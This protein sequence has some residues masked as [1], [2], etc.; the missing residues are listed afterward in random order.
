[1]DR[2]DIKGAVGVCALS[3]LHLGLTLDDLLAVSL[4]AK[5]I[6]LSLLRLR[7]PDKH[8][9]VSFIHQF[10]PAA[11]V[12]MLVAAT[13]EGGASELVKV[14]VDARPGQEQAERAE[15]LALAYAV[16]V[17]CYR[18]QEV[19]DW[20]PNSFSEAL[21]RG[22]FTEDGF[23]W[24]YL[25]H[26]GRMA[27]KGRKSYEPARIGRNLHLFNGAENMPDLLDSLQA[28]QSF[29]RDYPKALLNH[30]DSEPFKAFL[31][32]LGGMGAVAYLSVEFDD[33]MRVLK[34]F[35]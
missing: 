27:L 20:S 7:E 18:L 21:E 12:G 9:L 15:A 8:S 16:Y 6:A 31:S 29:I 35:K 26:L 13:V 3:D 10:T 17:A 22:D 5:V 30:V 2:N 28:L 14:L 19:A 11:A 34:V 4:D 25:L 23:K 24:F 33:E 1:M 32:Y